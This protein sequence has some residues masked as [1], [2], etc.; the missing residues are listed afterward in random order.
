MIPGGPGLIPGGPGLIPGGQGKYTALICNCPGRIAGL[1]GPKINVNPLPKLMRKVNI[2]QTY[3]LEIIE[4]I[5]NAPGSMAPPG[6]G[7]GPPGI[8]PGPPGIIQNQ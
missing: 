6:I 7:P 8:S 4:I 2:G 1:I 3:V 5:K